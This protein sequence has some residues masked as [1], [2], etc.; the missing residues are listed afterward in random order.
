MAADAELAA[1]ARR[2]GHSVAWVPSTAA[3]ILVA[4][5][6][7]TPQLAVLSCDPAI[8]TS[9]VLA[10]CD[11]R[12]IRIIALASGDAHRRHAAVLGLCEVI[13][14]TTDW[15]LV[16]RAIAGEQRETRPADG[17]GTVIAVWG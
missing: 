5:D 3:A 10:A 9:A 16:E 1:A 7:N 6:G 12:G 13:D 15:E 8:L 4:L 2:H 17:R 11:A 14:D